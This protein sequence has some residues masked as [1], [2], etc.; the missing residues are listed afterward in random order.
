MECLASL[1]KNE[2]NVDVEKRC[3]EIMS[4]NGIIGKNLYSIK[5]II[6][7]KIYFWVKFI[8]NIQKAM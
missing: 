1:I 6:K 3:H 8:A 5:N 2:I 4:I 7:E